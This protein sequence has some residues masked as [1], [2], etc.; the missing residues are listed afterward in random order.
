MV[1]SGRR[2]SARQGALSRNL[3]RQAARN[4]PGLCGIVQT[5]RRAH[6][7]HSPVHYHLFNSHF[8][9][10][11]PVWQTTLRQ[12]HGFDCCRDVHGF[13]HDLPGRPFSRTQYGFSDGAALHGRRVPDDARAPICSRAVLREHKARGLHFVAECLRAS[14][15]KSIP[16]RHSILS[17]LPCFYSSRASGG[18]R[19]GDRAVCR[20]SR[21]RLWGLQSGALPFLIYIAA[22]KSFSFYWLYV[23]DWGARYARYYPAW[24]IAVSALTQSFYYFAINNTLLIALVFV[25]V[26]VIKRSVKKQSDTESASGA[27]FKADVTLLVWLGVSYAGLAVGGRFFGHYFFQILP[28][29]CLIGARGLIGIVSALKLRRRPTDRA[30]RKWNLRHA[31]AVL[32]AVGFVIT[33]IRF[34]SRTVDTRSRLGARDKERRNA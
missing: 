25:I 4:R 30:A 33:L 10:T 15:L 23:W 31:L 21:L 13:Q 34:H 7:D 8:N 16:K 19:R 28:S 32:L 17:S 2:D 12:A 14:L 24:K 29:L 22:T 1:H 11:L 5:V 3:F 27:G 6:P 9:H 20:S 18:W 26:S